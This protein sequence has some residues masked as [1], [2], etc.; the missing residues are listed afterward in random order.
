MAAPCALIAS[1]SPFHPEEIVRQILDVAD[2]PEAKP[3]LE[4]IQSYDWH[5][6]TK[7]YTA[8]VKLCT[9]ATRTIGDQSF[10]ESV[11][12]FV[13]YFDSHE[14][15]SFE[16][17]K[18]WVPY[19][20][21]I[22]PPV[23]ILVSV[24][25]LTAQQW[26]IEH[27]F[28]LV[29]LEPE[30][31][32]DDEDCDFVESNGVK[33]IIQALHAHTWPNLELKS[34]SPVC[35]PYFR[36]LM[37]EEAALKAAAAAASGDDER[38][39]ASKTAACEESPSHLPADKLD[40]ATGSADASR[41]SL[42]S[43]TEPGVAEKGSAEKQ[44]ADKKDSASAEKKSAID[45]LVPE[46]SELAMLAAL[47]NEDPGE[48]SFEQLFTK[49]RLMKEKAST[50][51]PEERKTYA[52]KIAVTFWRAIGGDEDEIDGLFDDVDSDTT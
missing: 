21:H 9:T 39:D 15:S 33:R 5:I 2:L 29:E 48:E 26:C 18:S 47:G 45:D 11:Q 51:P 12:A 14:V 52:E 42:H 13:V 28:E 22:N 46:D 20:S 3:E 8:D 43:N 30:E 16:K 50:L 40:E 23:Q 10:A 34:R 7:Y 1:C 25:R 32:S 38:S 31:N 6:D 27:G 36:N 41:T 44:E 35:S 19:L 37:Q 17:V 4:C 49:L 24:S